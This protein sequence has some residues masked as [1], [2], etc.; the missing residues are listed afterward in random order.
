MSLYVRHFF[1]TIKA[2]KMSC[3]LRKMLHDFGK[4]KRVKCRAQ[5]INKVDLIYCC[6]KAFLEKM[7]GCV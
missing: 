5:Q 4:I 3:K 2:E 7:L 6:T 1:N